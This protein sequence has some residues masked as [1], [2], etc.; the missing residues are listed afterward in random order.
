MPTEVE[1]L[2][3]HWESYPTA[4]QMAEYESE[5]EVDYVLLQDGGID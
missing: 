1:Y 3:T 5:T 2:L 4:A